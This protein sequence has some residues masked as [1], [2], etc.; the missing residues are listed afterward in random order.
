MAALVAFS[1]VIACG[2]TKSDDPNNGGGGNNGGWSNGGG[3]YNGHEYVD[4]GLPSGTLWATCNVGADN[5]GDFG[6]YFAWGETQTKDHYHWDNY[7]YCMGS[8]TTQT[9]YCN[10]ASYGYNGYTDNLTVLQSGDDAAA[11][12]WGSGWRM[13]TGEEWLE[14]LNNTTNKTSV[15]NGHRGRLFTASNGKSLFLPHAG[16]WCAWAYVDN[17]YY[18]SSSLV[19]ANPRKAW[20]FSDYYGD[21]DY[22]ELLGVTRSYGCPVRAVRSVSQN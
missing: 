8:D 5:P 11:A 18:W 21:G 10:H 7:Q 12:Q 20:A 2:C 1:V 15:Q 9:K 6:D 13:P 3:T 17:K 16:S 14:L 19:S 22:C 4:L